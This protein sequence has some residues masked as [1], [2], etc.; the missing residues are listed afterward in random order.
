MDKKYLAN[1]RYTV[2]TKVVSNLQSRVGGGEATLIVQLH[3][4]FKYIFR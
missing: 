2:G 4:N 3:L 1:S